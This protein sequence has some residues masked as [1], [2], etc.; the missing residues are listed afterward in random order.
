LRTNRHQSR[1]DEFV[2]GK[3]GRVGK[4][5]QKEG[6]CGVGRNAAPWFPVEEVCV[7]VCV[8]VRVRERDE[9]VSLLTLQDPQSSA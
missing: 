7:C 8:C 2:R 9:L 5:T 6:N 4:K 3:E 1:V